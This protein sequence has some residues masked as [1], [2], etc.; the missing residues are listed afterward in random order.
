MKRFVSCTS[1]SSEPAKESRWF[2]SNL[3]SSDLSL[4]TRSRS[5]FHD[6]SFQHFIGI[7]YHV[8]AASTSVDSQRWERERVSRQGRALCAGSFRPSHATWLTQLSASLHGGLAPLRS[9]HLGQAYSPPH[10]CQ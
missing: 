9:H 8:T 1:G 4:P 5:F 10:Q 7:A 2:Q 3:F 6:A